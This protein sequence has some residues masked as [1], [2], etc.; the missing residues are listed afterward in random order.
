MVQRS[1]N[2][3]ILIAKTLTVLEAGFQFMA[4]DARTTASQSQDTLPLP[5]GVPPLRNGDRLTRDEFLRRYHAMP[6]VRHAEL[7]EGRVIMPSPV[8]A[9]HHGE[10]HFDFNGWLFV[11]RAMT[12]GVIGGD[13]STLNLDLDNAPQPDGYLRLTEACGGQS[14]MIDGYLSGAPE[15]VVEVAASSVSYDLHDKLNA[16]RRNGVREYVVWRTEDAA[17]DWFELVEGRFDRLPISDDGVYRSMIFPGLWLDPAAVI[18][19]DLA[20]VLKTLNDGLASESHQTF[21]ASKSG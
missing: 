12:P 16:Y 21:V 15:L 19:G 14:R 7:I 17:I 8:S 4:T 13:N 10:P 2:F 11:Y 5:N 9:A 3:H 20:S 6:N 1:Q 18:Q